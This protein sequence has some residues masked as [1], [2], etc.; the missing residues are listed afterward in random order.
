MSRIRTIK[1]EFFTSSDIVEQTPLSRLF[2]VSLW[3][4]ADREGR[5]NWNLKT[6]KMRYFPS[7]ECDLTAMAQ[8][9]IE[10]GLIVTYEVEGKQYADIPTFK[11]HQVIN[12]RESE[13]AI[14]PRVKDASKRRESGVQGEGKEG[15][16]GKELASD[17]SDFEKF[18]TAYPKK[19]NKGQAEKAFAKVNPDND[20]LQ[21]ILKAVEDA[22][23]GVDWLK[24]DGQ[25]I[26]FPATW[27]NAKGWEDETP[28]S[29][30]KPWEN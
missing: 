23:Q 1:P 2:Y 6:L 10:A 5:L 4:E 22:R 19:K 20:L 24:N 30:G 7:D 21:T 16:K 28:G 13:S 9:L 14:P 11:K 12:N 8:E 29:S 17:E 18:W 3:C 26:P 27:L 15:R 25:Y